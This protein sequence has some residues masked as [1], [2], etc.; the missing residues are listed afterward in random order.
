VDLFS[1]WLKTFPAAHRHIKRVSET[2]KKPEKIPNWLT[3]GITYLLPKSGDSK[4]VRNYRPCLTVMYK[5][6]PGIRD[7]RI[8]THL[9]KRN[10][11]P[12][13]QEG[14]HPRSK[15]CKDQ[16]MMSKAIYEEWKKRGTRIK[17]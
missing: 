2:I 16:L 17:V 11:L 1:A 14:C 9:E 6:L 12:A 13:E 4:G 15:E 5:I 8:S 10:L 7:R 3:T